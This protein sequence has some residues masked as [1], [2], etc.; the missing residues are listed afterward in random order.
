[1]SAAI[2]AAVAPQA[3][4]AAATAPDAAAAAA[5]QS[6]LQQQF[7][8]AFA[9]WDVD[10]D[11]VLNSRELRGMLAQVLPPGTAGR[12]EARYCQVGANMHEVAGERL[13]CWLVAVVSVR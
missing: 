12:E 9:A 1:V 5:V 6:C 7:A 8:E 3:L 13:A 4:T 11:G 2:A 10:G